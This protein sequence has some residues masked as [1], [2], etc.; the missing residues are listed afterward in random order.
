MTEDCCQFT[1]GL[2]CSKLTNRR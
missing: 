1:A 2:G